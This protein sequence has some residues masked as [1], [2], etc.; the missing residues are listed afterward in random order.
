MS[1]KE[2]DIFEEIGEKIKDIGKELKPYIDKAEAKL[3]DFD[4]AVEPSLDSLSD[5]LR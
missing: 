4:K 1:E 3:Y 5:K 2:K